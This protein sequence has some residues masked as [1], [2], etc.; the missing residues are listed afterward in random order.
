M[1]KFICIAMCAVIVPGVLGLTGCAKA[2]ENGSYTMTL[3]YFPETRTLEGEMTAEVVNTAQTAYETL[4]FQLWA[5]AYREGAQYAPVSELFSPAAYYDG[6]SYGGIAVTQVTGA[7]GYR[8]TGEDENILEVTLE[9]PLYPDERVTLGMTFTVTL[10]RVEHRLGVGEHAVTL[11]GFYPVLCACNGTQEHVYADLGDPFVSECADYDV[12]LTL[13]ASYTVAYT[14][15]G[16]RTEANGKAAYHVRAE[17]VR[18]FAMV[19]SEQFSMTQGSAEGVP[20]TYYYL[21]D[22]DPQRTLAAAQQSLSYYCAAFGDYAYPAYTVAQVG[23]PYGGMEYPMLSLIADDLRAE[24]TPLVVAHETAHQWWYA[25]V[26]SDQ[27]CEAWQDEGLAEFSAALFLDEH[28]E[29]GTTYGECVASAEAS[30]RAFFSV[31]SQIA[32]GERT[33]MRRALTDFAGEY[34]Y[35]NVVYDKGLILFDRVQE[36]LGREKTLAS[37]RAYVRAYSGTIAPPEAL[38]ACFTQRG[39]YA[40]GVFTSFLEGTCVI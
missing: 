18:D 31:W 21:D 40:E 1:K 2:P 12:T 7:A 29:Y 20:V 10:A 23:F 32:N 27:F 24:E 37:L 8:V 30:Y 14:G 19:C 39:A 33:S 6:E 22:P 4:C 16:E 25:M 9:Q 17:G 26:G 3:E 5:N 35:R 15:T 34:E 36:V 28:P 13:P 38:I 11:T